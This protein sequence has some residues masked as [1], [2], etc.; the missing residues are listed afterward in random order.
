MSFNWYYDG[1]TR[2]I[3]VPEMDDHRVHRYDL[4]LKKMVSVYPLGDVEEE[5]ATTLKSGNRVWF[6]GQAELP[7][8]GESPIQ[9]TPAPDPKFGWQGS[10]YRKAWTQEIGL[11]LWEHVEQVNVVAIPTGQLVSERENMMLH[12]LEGWMN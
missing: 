12:A 10:A 1:A 8:P 4:L 9:L 11:F 2:W 6:V 3:T 7:P 5:I